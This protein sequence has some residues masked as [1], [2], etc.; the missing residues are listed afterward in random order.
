MNSTNNV[1]MVRI[2]LTEGE[3]QL[4][5]LIKRL[6]KWEKLRGLTVFRGISGYGESGVVHDAKLIDLAMDLPL[7][8]EFFDQPE[9]IE[10]VLEHLNDYIK[11]GHIVT[12]TATTN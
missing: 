6:Q 1:T 10:P 7:V 9:K 2:Y 8:L 12:W 11:P 5:G 4:A 3:N